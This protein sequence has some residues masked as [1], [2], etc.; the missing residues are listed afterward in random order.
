MDKPEAELKSTQ[1]VSVHY[2]E[3]IYTAVDTDK[4]LDE[5][6][7]NSAETDP[8]CLIYTSGT[9]GV[10]GVL[11]THQSIQSNIDAPYLLLAEGAAE[12]K[13]VSSVF[14]LFRILMSIQQ[15]FI[16]RFRLDRGM[17]LRT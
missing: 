6:T 15:D 8:C 17:V 9:G 4:Q 7:H 10:E 12:D 2:L 3:D 13:A 5:I 14:C 16:C 1:D 11:L